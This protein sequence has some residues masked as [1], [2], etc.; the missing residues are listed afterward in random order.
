MKK[1][2]YDGRLI[3]LKSIDDMC[4]VF[5]KKYLPYIKM[6]LLNIWEFFFILECLELKPTSKA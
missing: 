3:G 6:W 2:D 5:N 4:I 1:G